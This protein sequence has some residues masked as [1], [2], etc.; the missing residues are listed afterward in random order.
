MDMIDSDSEGPLSCMQPVIIN[1]YVIVRDLLAAK[2][3]VNIQSKVGFRDLFS[4]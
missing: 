2:A 4:S 1:G 3:T